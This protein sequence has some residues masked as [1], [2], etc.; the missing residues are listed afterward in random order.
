ML[1]RAAAVEFKSGMKSCRI[2]NVKKP[3]ACRPTI[4][5]LEMLRLR[6]LRGILVCPCHS[7]LLRLSKRMKFPSG[8]LF[9]EGLHHSHP[10]PSVLRLGIFLSFKS[11]HV[12]NSKNM[13]KNGMICANFYCSNTVLQ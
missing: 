1:S 6:H 5:K 9:P 11:P 10:N 7:R 4:A 3:Q 8:R 13:C 2:L 12:F